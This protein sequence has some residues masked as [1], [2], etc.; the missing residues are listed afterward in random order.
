MANF[1][2]ISNAELNKDQ[3]SLPIFL[4]IQTFVSIQAVW[5]GTPSPVFPTGTFNIQVS[6]DPGQIDPSTGDV[7]GVTNWTVLTGS[8]YPAAGTAGNYGWDLNPIDYRWAQLTYT[9]T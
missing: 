1:Q 9:F 5:S 2:I 7:S 4:D 8:Q 3:T 6:N